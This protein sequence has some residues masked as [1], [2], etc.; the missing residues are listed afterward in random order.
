[1][2]IYIYTYNMYI[3]IYIAIAQPRLIPYFIIK[4]STSEEL[5]QKPD[6][7]RCEKI[8]NPW[9]GI[10]IGSFPT[11]SHM[12]LCST[13]SCKFPGNGSISCVY[14]YIYRYRHQCI[15]CIYIYIDSI[16][17]YILYIYICITQYTY[18]CRQTRTNSNMNTTSFICKRR[19]LQGRLASLVPNHCWNATC[20]II[21]F[22]HRLVS[23]VTTHRH[24]EARQGDS[25]TWDDPPDSRE[26]VVL[27]CLSVEGQDSCSLPH[28]AEKNP[29][30]FQDSFRQLPTIPMIKS[31]SFY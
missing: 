24:N 29:S 3:Y 25:L 23:G 6:A 26:S 1:M 18:N 16:Y 21:P 5:L 30:W 27:G 15:M 13:H 17:M 22:G 2:Y 4:G 7:S 8:G 20:N 9:S 19:L 28:S 11:I 14:I 12:F 31:W 10:Q